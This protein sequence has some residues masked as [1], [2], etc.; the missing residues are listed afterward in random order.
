MIGAVTTI[1]QAIGGHTLTA[2]I[3]AGVFVFAVS[4]GLAGARN[5]LDPFGVLVMASVVGLSGGIIRDVMLG[6]PAIVVFDWRVV[7]SVS[8][9]AAFAWLLRHR[10]NKWV[11]SIEVF[12]ALGL[13]LFCVIGTELAWQHHAAPVPAV[14]MGVVTATGGGVVRDV[15][16]R[17]VPAVLREGLYALPAMLGSLI[18]VIGHELHLMSLGWYALAAGSCLAVRL[19]GIIFDINLPQAHWPTH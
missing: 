12:D 6:V 18:V 15:V 10:L 17:E 2:L 14:L 19:L 7:V 16:L 5:R 9:A 8:A 11:A 4:G 1:S 3:V 13:A